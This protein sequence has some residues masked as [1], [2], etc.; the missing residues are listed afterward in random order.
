M[1]QRIVFTSSPAR[2]THS[3]GI[4]G[5]LYSRARARFLKAFSVINDAKL[6]GSKSRK[7]E[8]MSRRPQSDL[9]SFIVATWPRYC[10]HKPHYYLSCLHIFSSMLHSSDP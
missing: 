4:K 10:F 6:R 2:E 5:S 8:S 1:N 7:S 9:R 3:Q